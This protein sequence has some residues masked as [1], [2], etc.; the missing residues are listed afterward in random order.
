MEIPGHIEGNGDYVV[1][2]HGIP[3]LAYITG[4]EG[5][6]HFPTLVLQRSRRLKTP[7]D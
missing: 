4:N 7:K 3:D 2:S 6:R 5:E 1:F